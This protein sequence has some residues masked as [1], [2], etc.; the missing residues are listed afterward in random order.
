MLSLIHI[1]SI[2]SALYK[3]MHCDSLIDLRHKI[4]K[5]RLF[6]HPHMHGQTPDIPAARKH[7]AADFP[8]RASVIL[9]LPALFPKG[10][11]K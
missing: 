1:Y 3:H 4:P 10:H 11:E 7:T 9:R 8:E 5:R 6:I 2:L